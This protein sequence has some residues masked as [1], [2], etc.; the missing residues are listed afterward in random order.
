MGLLTAGWGGG[1]RPSGQTGSEA[2]QA[3]W[4]TG[5]VPG[6]A[7]RGALQT[8]PLPLLS[9]QGLLGG[10]D[11]DG[12]GVL[13]GGNTQRVLVSLD[14]GC[15]FW[16]LEFQMSALKWWL[17]FSTSFL[18]A[19]AAVWSIFQNTWIAP[20]EAEIWSQPPPPQKCYPVK[21]ELTQQVKAT[22]SPYFNWDLGC[23]APLSSLF[24]SDT[25][26]LRSPRLSLLFP[27]GTTETPSATVAEENSS[28]FVIPF[29][30]SVESSNVKCFFYLSP[31]SSCRGRR[32]WNGFL[33]CVVMNRAKNVQRVQLPYPGVWTL[34]FLLALH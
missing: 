17:L 29:S 25:R 14:T 13:V 19:A 23:F 27:I 12:V 1:S 24:R 5:Q 16:I 10:G 33:F 6:S 32:R 26:R 7:Y 11:G 21:S 34:L 20:L 18:R 9:H 3:D 31:S 4:Q 22:F 2:D 28:S 30:I 15:H 8:R